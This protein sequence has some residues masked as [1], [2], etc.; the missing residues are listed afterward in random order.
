M[1]QANAVATMTGLF[2]EQ[3]AKKQGF[4]VP[5]VAKISS[6]SKFR[7]ADKLGNLFHYPVY[8][9][10]EQGHTYA[11]DGGATTLNAS[12]AGVNLDAQVQ[13]RQ[14]FSRAQIS[15][16][17][18]TRVLGGTV[19]FVDAT[20]DTM[21]K[22]YEAH[23]RRREFVALYGQAPIASTS[24][25]TGSSTT[26][27]FTVTAATWSPG[28][29][30]GAVGRTLDIYATTST[31]SPTNTN[32]AFIVTSVNFST[33]VVTGTISSSD[34]A[35]L[36]AL[37]TAVV[38]FRGA[39]TG[40]SSYADAAG[41]DTI[42]TNTGTLFNIDAGTYDLWKGNT[43][44]AGSAALNMQKIQ[45][46]LADP[47]YAGLD[48]DVVCILSP[49]TWTDVMTDLAA[50]RMFDGSYTPSKAENGAENIVFHGQNGKIEFV[51]H[52][53][54]KEGEAF[55]GPLDDDMLTIGSTDVT[56]MIPGTKEPMFLHVPDTGA[57][58]IRCMSDTAPLLLHPAWW[59]KITNITNTT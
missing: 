52:I 8:V 21:M 24:E 15:Y 7:I 59:S 22:L 49:R 6:R 51:P 54:C 3:Y 56:S 17:A 5:K 36:D 57:Y 48:S 47:V 23:S 39:K 50:L 11:S 44:S 26:G 14:I 46:A 27:T 29:W 25:V 32:A 33:R 10:E 35:G 31:A 28:I 42:I 40:A 55:L 1:A 16:T 18:A 9:A 53:L 41:L 45:A 38:Y 37:T 20:K 2:T 43:Y 34:A 58:E 19:S 13:G 12:V 4:L 30:R